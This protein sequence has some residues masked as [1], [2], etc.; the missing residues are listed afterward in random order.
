MVKKKNPNQNKIKAGG[1]GGTEV[2][3]DDLRL[4]LL[5]DIELE[6]LKKNPI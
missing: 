3:P 4:L 2:P 5:T 6:G 1:M